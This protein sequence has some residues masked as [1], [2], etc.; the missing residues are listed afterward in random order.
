MKLMFLD[1]ETTG[2][3][4]FTDR[5][6]Q[7]SA[8]VDDNRKTV[9]EFNAFIHPGDVVPSNTVLD[10]LGVSLEDLR[11][12]GDQE[13]TVFHR[14]LGFLDPVVDRY[15]K[16]DKLFLVGHNVQFDFSFLSEFFR[17]NGND[18]LG[19]YVSTRRMIDTFQLV[20]FDNLLRGE[21][22]V[23]RS[24]RLEEIAKRRPVPV[25]GLHDSMVDVRLTRDIFYM[26]WD[27]HAE[28]R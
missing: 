21:T 14:F 1:L 28:K 26:V 7:L 20:N 19:S 11:K 5:P 10:I 6:V 22:D 18:F 24:F 23:N 17:R 8:I 3:K 2:V 25:S 15:D 9:A 12:R 27:R 4:P 16:E 13:S